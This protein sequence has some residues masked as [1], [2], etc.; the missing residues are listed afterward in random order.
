MWLSHTQNSC[1]CISSTLCFLY[2]CLNILLRI[3]AMSD[4]KVSLFIAT[5]LK[6]Y[7]GRT[8][9]N[10]TIS[11]FMTPKF[12]MQSKHQF[13]GELFTISHGIMDDAIAVYSRDVFCM[14]SLLWPWK[15]I[16]IW[17][18][19][20]DVKFSRGVYIATPNASARLFHKAKSGQCNLLHYQSLPPPPARLL[21]TTA[22]GQLVKV[23]ANVQ[24]QDSFL[25][26]HNDRNLAFGK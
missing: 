14:R 13:W 2:A 9:S 3:L 12:H 15:V 8:T 17:I 18:S 26:N 1:N 11:A 21:W 7:S 4:K 20:N 25:P 5:T 23:C 22:Y 6:N 16:C 10:L 24:D 19:L